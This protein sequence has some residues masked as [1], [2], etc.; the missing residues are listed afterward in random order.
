MSYLFQIKIGRLVQYGLH[1]E[2]T[3][4]PTKVETDI[5]MYMKIYAPLQQEGEIRL[6]HSTVN[7]LSI[8]ENPKFKYLQVDC[9][10]VTNT[11]PFDFDGRDSIKCVIFHIDP[12]TI[13]V[14]RVDQQPMLTDEDEEKVLNGEL[15][16]MTT[17]EPFGQLRIGTRAV[18]KIIQTY[19]PV[20]P[21]VRVY[22]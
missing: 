10:D 16:L 4:D 9:S 2:N 7:L 8:L 18:F 17:L 5:R 14:E 1:I 15:K 20:T 12:T 19:E 22:E 6:V 13:E 3:S 11:T 21:K